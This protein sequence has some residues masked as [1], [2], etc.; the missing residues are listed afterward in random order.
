MFYRHEYNFN[1]TVVKLKKIRGGGEGC[2]WSGYS[3]TYTV[4]PFT[5]V[6]Q[7]QYIRQEYSF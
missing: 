7:M 1:Q 2:L 4:D 6:F 3:Y 5:I